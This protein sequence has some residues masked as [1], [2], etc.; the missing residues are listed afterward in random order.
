MRNI[1]LAISLFLL[2]SSPAYALIVTDNVDEVDF[3][4]KVGYTFAS[5]D[6][7]ASVVSHEI[8][9]AVL[10]TTMHSNF[11]YVVPEEGKII[12]M[13]VA[14]S[15]AVAAGGGATFDVTING[16]VTGVQAIIQGA[17]LTALGTPSGS[18]DV[19]YSYIT[20]DRDETNAARGFRKGQPTKLDAWHDAE[21]PY[22]RATPLVAGN[23]VGVKVTTNSGFAPTGVDYVIVVYVLH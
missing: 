16:L 21:H 23:R 1:L 10:E 14:G 5:D 22:G 12:G 11:Y 7:A 17:S 2:I 13:A 8:S 19:R 4:Y 3:Q 6:V 9:V 18:S 15:E 20:Q